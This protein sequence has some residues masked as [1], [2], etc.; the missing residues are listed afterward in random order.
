VPGPLRGRRRFSVHVTK[1]RSR[2]SAKVATRDP[3]KRARRS[4]T[5]HQWSGEKDDTFLRRR[6]FSLKAHTDSVVKVG[7][8]REKNVYV[9]HV[10][11]I[12]ETGW[13]S[14][15]V[16]VRTVETRILLYGFIIPYISRISLEPSRSLRHFFL[17]KTTISQ[18]YF[19]RT[20]PTG[21][22]TK[23]DFIDVCWSPGGSS[24][25]IE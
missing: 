24:S 22:H 15:K 13:R 10:C 3:N 4:A 1:H 12:P 16:P 20:N 23:L 7:V 14:A 6:F 19:A 21:F 8:E 5:R 18:I 25:I 17:W 2:P 9:C 11:Q